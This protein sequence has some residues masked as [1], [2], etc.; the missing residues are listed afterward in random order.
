MCDAIIRLCVAALSKLILE[1]VI[2]F[3]R[4]GDSTSIMFVFYH[5]ANDISFLPIHI[6]LVLD[7]LIRFVKLRKPLC[8]I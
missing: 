2:T 7:C 6:V 8:F 1:F 3:M 5:S 4:G